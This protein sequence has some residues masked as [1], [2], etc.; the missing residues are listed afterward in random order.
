VL[1]SKKPINF[2]V[3]RIVFG[4]APQRYD[5]T[6]FARAGPWLGKLAPKLGAKWYGSGPKYVSAPQVT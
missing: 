6:S 3:G 2:Q 5:R 4:C 1:F